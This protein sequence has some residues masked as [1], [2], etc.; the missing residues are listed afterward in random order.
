MSG[1][2]HFLIAMVFGVMILGLIL[3][4]GNSSNAIL[5]DINSLATTLTLSGS[6]VPYHGPNS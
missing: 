4:Y 1:N 3:R 6:N 5:K 2:A